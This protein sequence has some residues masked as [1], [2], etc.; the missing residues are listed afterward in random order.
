MNNIP[1]PKSNKKEDIDTTIIAIKKH[2]EDINR[3]LG[4][5]DNPE[6]PDLSGFVT[7]AELQNSFVNAVELDNMKGATSNAV[8]ESMEWEDISSRVTVTKDTAGSTTS[9]FTPSIVHC[10]KC[11]NMIKIGV[12][13]SPTRDIAAPSGNGNIRFTIQIDGIIPTS[14]LSTTSTISYLGTRVFPV[15]IGYYDEISPVG[16]RVTLRYSQSI[17]QNDFTAYCILAI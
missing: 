12:R 15:V 2:L 17:S 5:V 8:A 9:Y 14:A 16:W 3:L 4:L 6:S 11:R 13:I 10:Y 1:L 7:R